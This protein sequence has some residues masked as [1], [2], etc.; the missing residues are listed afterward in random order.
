MLVEFKLLY[1]FLKEMENREYLPSE[2]QAPDIIFETGIS[3]TGRG[4]SSHYFF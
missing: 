1:F 4:N 2:Y 3:K